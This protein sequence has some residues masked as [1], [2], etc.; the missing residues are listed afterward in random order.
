MASV[1][2]LASVIFSQLVIL[3]SAQDSN[4]PSSFQCGDLGVIEF[5][6][7]DA[8]HSDCGLFVIHGCESND[9]NLVKYI[10][11][12][13]ISELFQVTVVGESF[14]SVRDYRFQKELLSRNCDA[15][16]RRRSLPLINSALVSFHFE[17]KTTEM[18]RCNHTVNATILAS[19]YF[20]N[21]TSCPAYD[22]YFGHYCDLYFEKT[23]IK[24]C[25]KVQLRIQNP[26]NIT[27]PFSS[28]A[29][30]IPIRVQVSYDCNKCHYER[31][32]Q[33][34][35]DT[36]GQ[37]FCAG[38]SKGKSVIIPAAG[39]AFCLIYHVRLINSL[40]RNIGSC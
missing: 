36:K 18:I 27:D 28:V 1:S 7:T 14:V 21:Y 22:L 3:L 37:F 26:D 23:H 8:E 17:Y 35:L 5:P 25:S 29:A 6:F 30:E 38:D 24:E 20:S 34:R 13:N 9:P 4:C 32:G 10:Q 15:F 40:L 19:Y 12:N 16:A 2:I 11:F 39:D 31:G 33:C